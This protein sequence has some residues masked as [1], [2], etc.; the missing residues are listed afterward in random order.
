MLELPFWVL[1]KKMENNKLENTYESKNFITQTYF[2]TKVWLAVRIA[3]IKRDDVILDFGCGDGWLEKKLKDYEIYGYDINPEKT[4][5][6]D[7]KTIVP[8]KI[9]VLDVFEHI[10][11]KEIIKLLNNFKRL[12]KKFDLIVS[13]P[14]ENWLSRKVR[15]L[16]GKSEV[17]EEHI[18]NH[19][20]IFDILKSNFKLKKRINFFTVSKIFIFKYNSQ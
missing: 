5:I 13:V 7:Y 1:I 16:V 6:K 14:T 11:E 8:T 3:N 4:F 15:K 20:K 12:N 9:F 10:P 17:P 2:K 18:T 19:K